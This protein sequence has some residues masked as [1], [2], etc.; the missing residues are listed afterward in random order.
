MTRVVVDTNCLVSRLLLPVS[1]PAQAVESAIISGT[2]LASEATLT[3]LVEVLHRKK[4]RKYLEPEDIKTFLHM[5]GRMVEVIPIQRQVTVC[6]NPKDNQFL[7]VALNGR[8]E[9]LITGDQ[10]L[11]QLDPFMDVCILAPKSFCD[12]NIA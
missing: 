11:L 3:E 9:F 8:A 4:F 6:R 1:I 10:D 5:L 7:D 12:L 2:L